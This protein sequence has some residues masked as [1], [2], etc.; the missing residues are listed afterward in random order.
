MRPRGVDRERARSS[1][2]RQWGGMRQGRLLSSALVLVLLW[3]VPVAA[4]GPTRILVM[5]FENVTR[6]SR[7]FWLTEAAA[8]LLID[9]LNTLGVNAITRDE[10][11]AAFARLEVPPA[12]ALTD[13]TVIRIAQLVGASHVIVGTLRLE[14]DVLVVNARRIALDAG[15]IERMAFER[16]PVPDLYDTFE[17]AAR[18]LVSLEGPA[19]GRDRPPVAAF[20][21]YVKGL[22]AGTPAT[23][24]GY[25]N[26]ALKVHPSFVEPRLALWAVYSDQGDHGRALAAVQKVPG[27]SPM[28]ARARFLSGLSQLRLDRPD[29]AF[30]TYRSLADTRPSANVFNNLG[31]AQLRRGAT[32]EAGEA[33]YYFNRAVETDADEP[34]YCFNL[35]YAFWMKGDPHAAVYW[36]REA[37]RRNPADGDAHFV[38]GAALAAAGNSGEA[39]RERD[40]AR[41]L[42]SM[43]LEWEKR[44]RLDPVPKGLERVKGDVDLPHSGRA[45]EYLA[46]GQRDQRAVALFH[47]DRGRRLFDQERD[48]D[49]LDELN[50][51]LFL[52]PYEADAHLLVGRIYLRGGRVADAIDALKISLMELRVG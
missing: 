47:L 49:V 43:Y 27:D 30:A 37:V 32:A 3:S 20:E 16:G 28:A 19:R 13:A 23:A 12:A 14:D 15:R 7:I 26:A 35:G 10:R 9:E 4:Q 46:A 42:S 22:L 31:V 29:E 40:L 18:Q 5:P 25:L 34:D 33:T 50:R 39:N 2:A 45:Q 24:I 51:T 8:V 36:L 17:R 41:R 21:N 44:P 48:R 6:E 1:R 11:R 38:L 52:S